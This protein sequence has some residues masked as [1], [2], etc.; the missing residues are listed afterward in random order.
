MMICVA[1]LFFGLLSLG[2]KNIVFVPF[3]ILVPTPC[4]NLPISF[5]LPISHAVP[6]LLLDRTPIS[7]ML[8]VAGLRAAP[9][10]CCASFS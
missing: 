8:P 2:M 5:A 3:G 4:A 1:F 6:S 7:H 10:K 9:T